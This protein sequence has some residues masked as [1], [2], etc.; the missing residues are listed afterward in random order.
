MF[1]LR[2]LR[3]MNGEATGRGVGPRGQTGHNK[4]IQR[5]G[6]RRQ[7]LAGGREASE[8]RVRQAE[9]ESLCSPHV[10]TL[11]KPVLPASRLSLAC[12]ASRRSGSAHAS[13]WPSLP[14][15]LPTA[16]SSGVVRGND[17]QWACALLTAK[18]RLVSLRAWTRDPQ[19]GLHCSGLVCACVGGHWGQQVGLACAS[20]ATARW[21]SAPSAD[22]LLWRSS[23]KGQRGESEGGRGVYR[24]REDESIRVP[25]GG[26]PGQPTLAARATGRRHSAHSR[27]P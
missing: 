3:K 25:Q 5:D 27:S 20:R 17:A 23:V 22:D 19:A 11:A 6:Q 21:A 7:R 9:G 14:V 2:T 12:A 24:G 8:A 1:G 13:T 15:P 18:T 16:N 4:G 26:L 10:R